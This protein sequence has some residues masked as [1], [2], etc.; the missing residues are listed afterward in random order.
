MNSN[1]ND[2]KRVF[3]IWVCMNV[4]QSSI[5]YIHLINDAILGSYKWKG[6]L[7][8]LNIV[9]IG[10]AKEL[11][12]CEGDYELHRLLGALLSDKLSVSEK[13]GIMEME[14]NIPIEDD[15]RKDVKTM[16]NLSQGI[17]EDGIAIGRKDGIA[18]GKIEMILNMY[19]HNFSFE[20]IAIA[21]N[22]SIE[23]VKAIIVKGSSHNPSSSLQSF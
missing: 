4:N 15:F 2:I 18:I 12:G 16:C 3:S 22:K 7:D 19:N 6:K 23:E 13:L 1:Y 9:L 11:Q 17:R 5:N 8:L 20:Q 10:I 14:Y 21:A